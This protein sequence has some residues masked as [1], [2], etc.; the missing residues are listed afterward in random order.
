MGGGSN[1]PKTPAAKYPVKVKGPVGK[2]IHHISVDRLRQFTNDK[3]YYDDGILAY[4]LF[5]SSSLSASECACDFACDQDNPMLDLLPS[6]A[7][8][9]HSR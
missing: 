6:S 5:S 9:V 8:L 4:V 1:T 3:E 7:S 2:K